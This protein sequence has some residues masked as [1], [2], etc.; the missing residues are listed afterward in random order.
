MDQMAVV[1]PYE[2]KTPLALA[3]QEGHHRHDSERPE[4]CQCVEKSRKA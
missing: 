3:M 2:E 4:I 1:T